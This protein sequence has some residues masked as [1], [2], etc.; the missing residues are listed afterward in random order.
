MRV[1][2]KVLATTLGLCTFGLGLQARGETINVD[3]LQF[4]GGVAGNAQWQYTSDMTAT[5][6]AV[7][8]TDFFSI[9]GVQ[10]FLNFDATHLTADTFTDAAGKTWDATATPAGGGTDITV[11]YGAGQPTEF[12]ANLANS[13]TNLV[14]VTFTDAFVGRAAG[15]TWR[16]QDHGV[17]MASG[18]PALTGTSE[19]S[20]GVVDTPAS[21]VPLPAAVSGGMALFGL[22]AGTRRR[23]RA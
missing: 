15:P 23:R 6:A 22:I 5:G 7:N 17:T 13:L 19:T 11:T 16:S 10:G 14:N 18:S 1:R 9:T 2:T 20:A 8:S 21:G 12:G 3:G 4:L